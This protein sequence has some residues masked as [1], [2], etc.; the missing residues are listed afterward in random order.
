MFWAG[1]VA[2]ARQ[3]EDAPLAERVYPHEK[4]EFRSEF[5]RDLAA[6]GGRA[7]KA[8]VLTVA[9][10]EIVEQCPDISEKGL[11]KMLTRYPGIDFLNCNDMETNGLGAVTKIRY[12]NRAGLEEEIPVSALKDRLSRAKSIRA[13]RLARPS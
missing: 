5:L 11:R 1:M 6:K 10:R 12:E 4:E 2:R 9:I 8:D 3:F 13:K 7:P